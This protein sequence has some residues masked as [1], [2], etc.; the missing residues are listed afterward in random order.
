MRIEDIV[1]MGWVAVAS[2]LLLRFSGERGLFDPGQPV[3]GILR[4][5]AVVGVLVCLAVRKA[6][7]PTGKTQPSMVNRGVVGPFTG[8]LL[9]VT[10]TG[11]TALGASSTF[12]L[13]TVLFAA[14]C[15]VMARFVLPPLGTA[16]RRALVSPFAIISGGL[17]WSFIAEVLPQSQVAAVRH[18]AVIDPHAATPIL[19]FLAGFS[20]VYYAMLIYAPRQIAERE[21]GWLEWIARYGAFVASVALGLGWL[22]V[23]SG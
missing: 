15:V 14:V 8:G 4:L 21:G 11:F 19:L 16:G 22:S 2:P 20:V 5:A 12:V 7:D 3:P 1:L 17:Y 6:P 9:L 10:I 13:A 18:A 23:L